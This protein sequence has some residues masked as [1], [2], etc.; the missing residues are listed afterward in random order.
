MTKKILLSISLAVLVAGCVSTPEGK[1]LF[2]QIAQNVPTPWSGIAAGVLA[3]VSGVLGFIAKIKSDKAKLL[4]A[5]IS[6]IEAAGDAA[7]PVKQSIQN[8]ATAA[9][10]Q[11]QLHAEVQRL[12]G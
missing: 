7:A 5:V 1:G 6:G 12:T 2:K 4:P 11:S 10:V 8:I 9:G 3:G